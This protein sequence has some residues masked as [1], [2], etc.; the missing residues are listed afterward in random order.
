MADALV[1][2]GS[3][4]SEVLAGVMRGVFDPMIRSVY[5]QAGI[6]VGFA[7]DSISA[8]FPEISYPEEACVRALAVAQK[9]QEFLAEQELV[10]TPYGEFNITVKIGL[11]HGKSSWK[12]VKT[13]DAK[14]AIYYFRGPALKNAVV[15]LKQANSNEIILCKNFYK[16]LNENVTVVPTGDMFKLLGFSGKSLQPGKIEFDP[17]DPVLSKIFYSNADMPDG[18]FGEFRPAVN[19]FISIQQDEE[20]VKM[21]PLIRQV[22]RMQD[23][24][25]GLLCRPDFGDKGVNLLLFWGAPVA[26]END[27]VRALNFILELLHDSV[28]PIK[29]GVSYRQAYAGFMGGMLQEEYTC[30]GWGVS[31]A[32]RMMTAAQTGDIWV[33]EEVARQADMMFQLQHIGQQH[34]KGFAR[35]QKVYKLIRRKEKVLDVFTGAFVGRKDELE[36][37]S[38]FIAPVWDGKIAGLMSIIGEPGIGKSHLLHALHTSLEVKNRDFHWAV[39]QADE[40]V[41]A[42]LN[43]FRYWLKTYFDLSEEKT[44]Q[45][46]KQAFDTR[47]NSLIASLDNEEFVHIIERTRP[48]LGALVDL[49]WTDSAYD[50]MDPQGR[51]ENTLIA[52]ST[53]IRAESLCHPLLLVFEDAQYLDEDTKAFLPFL[54]RTLMAQSKINYPISILVASRREI[55]DI[56]IDR[57]SNLTIKLGNLSQENLVQLAKQTLGGRVS[58][59]LIDILEKR[60]EG[61]PFYTRQILRYLVD[62]REL[63]IGEQGWQFAGKTSPEAIPADVN[64]ILISFLDRLPRVVKEA[65]LTS[66]VLG[67]EFEVRL[68]AKILNV[69]EN[70]PEIA[71]LATEAEIWAPLT[72]TRYIFRQMLLQEAAYNMQMPA[73]KRELHKNTAKAIETLYSEQLQSHYGEIAYH[74][75]KAGLLKKASQHYCLAGDTSLQAYQNSLAAEYYTRALSMI[76]PDGI[77]ERIDLL[78]KREIAYAT[79]GLTSDQEQDLATLEL[80]AEQGKNKRDRAIVAQ[81]QSIFAF[82]TGNYKEA[83][84]I[85]KQAIQLAEDAG[86]LEIATRIYSDLPIAL[87]RQNKIE[88]AIHAAQR[89][90]ALARQVGSKIHEGLILNDVGL[91]MLQERESNKAYIH[92]T[93]SLEIAQ[94]TGDRRLEAQ[95]LNNLGNVVGMIRYEY[96]EAEKLFRN[97]LEIVREIGNRKG[98]GFAL[99]NLGWISAMQGDFTNARTYQEQ[100]LFIARETG[101]R[102]QESYSLINLSMLAVAQEDYSHACNYAQ[103]ALDLTRAIGDRSG[104]AWA[105]TSLGHAYLGINDLVSAKENYWHAFDIRNELEQTSLGTEPLAGLI[106]TAFRSNDIETAKEYTKIILDYLDSGGTL[107]GT[108]E[109]TRIYLSIYLVLKEVH[110]SRADQVLDSAYQLLLSQTSTL[111][112]TGSRNMYINNVPWRRQIAELWKTR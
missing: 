38:R 50:K 74:Q 75:E 5:E 73:R 22:M 97:T 91:I 61:N 82:N 30:Y 21:E 71:N 42:S 46:N 101:N 24:Y 98:E 35:E 84:E 43:P 81:R 70:L 23:R 83:E 89:G 92:F 87:A 36:I 64:T 68:L 28:I 29:A 16:I 54:G 1:Q 53:L 10:T 72:E 15:A 48:F 8:L 18:K 6:L 62:E 105:L 41:R 106:D 56:S 4:G 25:G 65:V 49:Y 86:S 63:E 13:Q 112:D 95:A 108:E 99:S 37:L 2:Y 100:S 26:Q 85:A 7:G 32:A 103:Q 69:K 79:L 76:S 60:A 57:V 55:H 77:H 33:D 14:R 78:L 96:P 52:L 12:I 27:I 59:D 34:F 45:E 93:Q 66:S 44:E 11:G 17:P 110:D 80:L 39:C 107:E 9:I 94:Q 31:L 20:V 102:Y 51:Y 58:P 3:H 19:L 47:L 40:I 90:I 104:Q 109:P 67:R 88:D 111:N